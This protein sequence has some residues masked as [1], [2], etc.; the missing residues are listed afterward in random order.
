MPSTSVSIFNSLHWIMHQSFSHERA[1]FNSGGVSTGRGMTNLTIAKAFSK[2]NPEIKPVQHWG[3]DLGESPD[4]LVYTGRCQ[5]VCLHLYV[6]E[7]ARS[8]LI[9]IHSQKFKWHRPRFVVAIGVHTRARAC[10]QAAPYMYNVHWLGPLGRGRGDYVCACSLMTCIPA[11]G[12]KVRMQTILR[13]NAFLCTRF[14]W[15]AIALM[16][17]LYRVFLREFDTDKE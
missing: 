8:I 9:L 7:D 3:V 10:S 12:N 13:L 1:V 17:T 6:T 14:E 11:L 4:L 15:S 5:K 2:H 16:I